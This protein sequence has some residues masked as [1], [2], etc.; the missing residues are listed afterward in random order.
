MICPVFFPFPVTLSDPNPRFEG[1]G[2]TFRPMNALN[3]LWAQLKGDLFVI[4]KCLF[5]QEKVV[6]DAGGF[7][8]AA[9]KCC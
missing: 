5:N 7:N 8:A 4:A 3:V 6:T 9:E 1:H 2:V